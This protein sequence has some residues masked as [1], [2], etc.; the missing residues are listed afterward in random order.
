M[1]INFVILQS[2][3]KLAKEFHPDKNPEAGDRFKEIAFAYEVL[4]DPK[5]KQ[6]YDR[7]GLKGIQEGGGGHDHGFMGEDLFSHIFG[8]GLF[9]MPGMGM[10][11]GGGRGR[12]RGEDTVHPLK[13]DLNSLKKCF[14]CFLIV[15]YLFVLFVG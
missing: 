9:G 1:L 12:R 15:T 6:I 11:F 10:H 8:G 3:R 13:Y 7:Y 2:Y 14:E 5:K 4:S